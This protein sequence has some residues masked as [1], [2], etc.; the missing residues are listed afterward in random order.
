MNFLWKDGIH[1]NIPGLFE[2]LL[3]FRAGYNLAAIMC[4]GCDSGGG[5]AVIM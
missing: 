4:L 2:A 1:L 5:R 3:I